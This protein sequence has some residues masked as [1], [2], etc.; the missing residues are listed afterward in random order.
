MLNPIVAGYAANHHRVLPE[1]VQTVVP[2]VARPEPPPM[3]PTEC[4]RLR[5]MRELIAEEEA[6]KIQT[7][8]VQRQAGA[9]ERWRSTTVN[10]N[11]A[12]LRFGRELERTGM[13]LADI[14][15]TLWQEAG[16]GRHP[17]ERRVQVKYIMR[18]LRGCPSRMAA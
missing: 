10:G 5:R 16:H 7:I 1:P 9:I 12:F 17:S 3:P 14:D 6:A 4:P 11:D 18:S 8:R 15:A 13:S 2:T